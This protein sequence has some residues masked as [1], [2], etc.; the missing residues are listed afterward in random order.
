MLLESPR[1]SR[2]PKSLVARAVKAW[3]DPRA[4]RWAPRCCL[5]L[6]ATSLGRRC[7]CRWAVMTSSSGLRCLDWL[8]SAVVQTASHTQYGGGVFVWYNS[9]VSAL[10]SLCWYLH[11]GACQT[12]PHPDIPDRGASL[13]FTLTRDSLMRF[14]NAWSGMVVRLPSLG[15]HS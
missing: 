3:H 4:E 9:C 8:L 11:Q 2:G 10:V 5:A 15:L 14:E 12:G 13:L 1:A 6:G 7:S